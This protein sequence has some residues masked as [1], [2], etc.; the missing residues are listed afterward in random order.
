MMR[1]L[2]LVAILVLIPAQGIAAEPARGA[3]AG[4]APIR[5]EELEV[6]GDAPLRMEELEVRGLRETPEILYLPVQ[7][8]ID[9][10][11]PVRYD[12]FLEDMAR[13]VVPPGGSPGRSG[14]DR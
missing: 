13:P 7:R 2:R 1:A 6:R 5:M 14:A 10:P 8:V 4:N 11:S 9:L 12:L 3:G